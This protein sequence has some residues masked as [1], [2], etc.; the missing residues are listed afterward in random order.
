M[1]TTQVAT[2]DTQSTRVA[3]LKEGPECVERK[4]KSDQRFEKTKES[5]Y[6]IPIVESSERSGELGLI[7]PGGGLMEMHI[8]LNRDPYIDDEEKCGYAK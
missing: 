3:D 5:C 4:K 2:K 6:S 1:S 8:C 7:N